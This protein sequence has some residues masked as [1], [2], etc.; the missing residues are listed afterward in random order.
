MSRFPIFSRFFPFLLQIYES[1]TEM[2]SKKA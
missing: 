1:K 2:S